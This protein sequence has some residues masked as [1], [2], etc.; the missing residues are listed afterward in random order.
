[1]I[2][3]LGQRNT[4]G[5]GRHY[6]GFC[7]AIKSRHAT[8]EVDG[9][10]NDSVGRESV[11]SEDSDVN[12][13]F[14]SIDYS[15]IFR[16][17]HIQWTVFETTKIPDQVRAVL[18]PADAIWVP[19]SWG[20]DILVVN[21]YDPDR[22][23]IVPEG[24]D[25]QWH[26]GTRIEPNQ[27][28][29]FLAVGK[30]ETRKGLADLVRSWRDGYANDPG[31]ELVIKT[32]AW[33]DA[34]T[35]YQELISSIQGMGNV[36]VLWG[37]A[38]DAQMLELYHSADAFILPTRGEGWGLPIIEAA[39]CGLPII[40]IPYSGQT[41]YLDNI[42]TSVVPIAYDLHPA[43]DTDLEFCYP[44]ADRDWGFWA[45]PREDA[46]VQAIA[47]ARSNIDMLRYHAN[48]NSDTIRE[49]YSWINSVDRAIKTLE[50]RNLI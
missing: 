13:S 38:T 19:S 46:I 44:R 30:Y 21:G 47:H 28:L 11:L 45:V 9:F 31:V 7:D 5:V 10:S 35:R 29:R 41:E 48:R 43:D 49:R 8:I 27:R 32:W 22:I 25:L 23:D 18:D 24:V 2:R 42:D 15:R 4:T 39:A 6:I 26:P 34:E 12:V 14:V 17:R 1:M 16:G 36:T 20:R 50:Q 3:L 33:R 37:Y 40:T